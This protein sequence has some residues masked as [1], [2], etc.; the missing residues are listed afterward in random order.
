MRYMYVI[1]DYTVTSVEVETEW[2]LTHYLMK[3]PNPMGRFNFTD[4]AF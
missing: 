3:T 1:T 2:K 4:L